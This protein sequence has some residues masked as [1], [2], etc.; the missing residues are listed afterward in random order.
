MRSFVFY[1]LSTALLGSLIVLSFPCIAQIP[2]STKQSGASPCRLDNSAHL[3]V[4]PNKTGGVRGAQKVKFIVSLGDRD[5]EAAVIEIRDKN[6]KLLE[7]GKT[8]DWG[9]Y[10][11]EVEPGTYEIHVIWR[12]LHI[13][14]QVRVAADTREVRL[15]LKD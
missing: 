14:Q 11:A 6:C 9:E 5:I 12:E 10:Y 8:D 3:P 2:T 13:Q 15:S 1:E 7:K 4:D